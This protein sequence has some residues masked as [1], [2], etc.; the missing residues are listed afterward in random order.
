MINYF[1]DSRLFLLRLNLTSFLIV[2]NC[3]CGEVHVET[4]QTCQETV[5]ILLI[6]YFIVQT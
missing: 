2:F 4:N 3:I 6:K 1:I 5:L